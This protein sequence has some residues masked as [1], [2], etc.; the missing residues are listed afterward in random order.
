MNADR[1]QEVKALFAAA[2]DRPPSDR[3]AFLGAVATDPETRREVESLLAA[4]RDDNFLGEG[5]G[6]RAA[7]AIADETSHAGQR[8]GAYRIIRA[9]GEGG[10]GVVFLAERDD[11]T[12]EKQVAIKVARPGALSEPA[13]R[14]FRQERQIIATLE[15]AYI[16][17]LLDGGTTS[18]GLPYFVL[19]YVDG[20]PIDAWCES[21]QLSARDRIQLFLLICSAV[22]Y[23]HAHG[24]V[25]RDLKPHNI[26]VTRDGTPRLLDFGIAAELGAG[27]DTGSMTAAMM[28]PETRVPSRFVGRRRHRQVTLRARRVAASSSE[29]RQPVSRSHR[30][31]TRASPAICEQEPERPSVILATKGDRTCAAL[32]RGDLDSIVLTAMRKKPDQ[33]YASVTALADDLRR[34]LDGRPIAARG[35]ESVYRA[36]KLVRR[37]KGR[38]AAAI[39][40]AISVAAAGWAVFQTRVRPPSSTS[41]RTL[42]VLPFKPLA[43]SGVDDVPRRGH[44]GCTDHA[45]GEHP[46]PGR[47]AHQQRGH[48]HRRECRSVERGPSTR[49]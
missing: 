41:V 45:A 32:V 14:R 1:W 3:A 31:P 42:A 40:V 49:S 36:A 44:G 34:H 43:P 25:H 33:R 28:T 22:E 48:L 10:M 30:C 26:L 19:E 6:L 27:A 39:I 15:H 8:V 38:L 37:H 21:N 35:S 18:D 20:V 17:R 2:L 5:D 7:A 23:A 13:M 24:V 4:H 47:A 9:I 16:A 46:R 12:F 11:E 29:R